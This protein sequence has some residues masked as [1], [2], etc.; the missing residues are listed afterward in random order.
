[1]NGRDIAVTE[2]VR[3]AYKILVLK[4]EIVISILWAYFKTVRGGYLSF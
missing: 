2:D 4:P 1:V 3:N